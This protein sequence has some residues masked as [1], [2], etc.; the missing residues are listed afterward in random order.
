MTNSLS[1]E[2]NLL[3]ILE[4]VNLRAYYVI[5]YAKRKDIDLDMVA[6]STDNY[7]ELRIYL[8]TALDNAKNIISTRSRDM[9]AT[10]DASNE[11]ATYTITPYMPKN[12]AEENAK[13]IKLAIEDYLVAYVLYKW[14]NNYNSN[15]ASPQLEESENCKG[16]IINYISLASGH[17]RRR[18]T[19]LGGI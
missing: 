18:A 17:I 10:L 16:R 5:E 19:D 1:F 9:V 3:Q 8:N 7:D 4:K 13:S 12:R 15:I 14:L 2:I 6:S 11:I